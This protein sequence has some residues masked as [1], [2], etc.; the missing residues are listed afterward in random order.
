MS[1]GIMVMLMFSL[2]SGIH[3]AFLLFFFTMLKRDII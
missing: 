1:P 2:E 3:F